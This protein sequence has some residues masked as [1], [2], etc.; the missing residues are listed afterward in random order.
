MNG[1]ESFVAVTT[2]LQLSGLVAASALLTFSL[3]RY[4]YQVLYPEGVGLIAASLLLLTAGAVADH[5]LSAGSGSVALAS[6]YLARGAYTAASVCIAAGTWQ[7]ARD[8]VT[9]P[10]EG[11]ELSIDRIETAE[12][13][14]ERGFEHAD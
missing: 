7:F 12:D 13:S 9:F 4:R 11:E 8:F 1:Y 2:A 10:S 14:D 5:L 6:D 3:V